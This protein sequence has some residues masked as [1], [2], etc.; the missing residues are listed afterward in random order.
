MPSWQELGLFLLST[1]CLCFNI[2]SGST[3]IEA[4]IF[5]TCN[6]IILKRYQIFFE[7]VIFQHFGSQSLKLHNHNLQ[8]LPFQFSKKLAVKLR[9]TNCTNSKLCLDDL[10]VSPHLRSIRLLPPVECS[11][12][13]SIV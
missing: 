2:F 8:T 4:A 12:L 1:P 10:K 9:L 11:I 7:P 6:Y 5:N 13:L 3:K